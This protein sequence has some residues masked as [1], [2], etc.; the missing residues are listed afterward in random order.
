MYRVTCSVQVPDMLGWHSSLRH[1]Q[2]G[3]QSSSEC[4]RGEICY[5]LEKNAPVF[6]ILKTKPK[7]ILMPN[8][9]SW[10]MGHGLY[11]WAFD[12]LRSGHEINKTLIKYRCLCSQINYQYTHVSKWLIVNNF[13][14]KYSSNVKMRYHRTVVDTNKSHM[15]VSSEEKP[16]CSKNNLKIREKWLEFTWLHIIIIINVINKACFYALGLFVK[17]VWSDK[18]Y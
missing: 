3:V 17:T 9:D 13:I 16:E 18:R 8:T 12:L 14:Q 4:L 15:D 5:L 7:M 2:T 11:H 6:E 1:G 10:V